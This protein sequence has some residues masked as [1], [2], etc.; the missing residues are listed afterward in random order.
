MKALSGIL[1]S[2]KALVVSVIIMVNPIALP[3]SMA[4]DAKVIVGFE[5]KLTLSVSTLED[6]LGK[7][8]AGWNAMHGH[9]VNRLVAP[10]L[11]VLFRGAQI[12][13][14]RRCSDGK[15]NS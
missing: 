5:G 2:T 1:V 6:A 12:R 14:L 4:F 10:L 15:P 9:L 3:F 11:D 7:G 8:N 13:R